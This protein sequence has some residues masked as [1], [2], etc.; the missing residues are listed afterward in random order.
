MKRRFKGFLGVPI[1]F[2][3]CLLVLPGGNVRAQGEKLP[4]GKYTLS[5]DGGGPSRQI[6]VQDG[7][8]QTHP[9]RFFDDVSGS[10][11][12]YSEA[13]HE[14]WGTIY[15]SPMGDFYIFLSNGHYLYVGDSSG[16]FEE[17]GDYEEV[18]DPV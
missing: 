5:P 15:K 6:E 12:E 9:H 16:G 1:F 13:Q 14:V 8:E 2:A 18:Q 3:L 4:D 7:Q 17:S 10:Q 11:R